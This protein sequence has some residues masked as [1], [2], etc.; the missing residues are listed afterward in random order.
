MMDIKIKQIENTDVSLYIENINEIAYTLISNC[1]NSNLIPVQISECH[2][3]NMKQVDIIDKLYI[4][5]KNYCNKYIEKFSIKIDRFINYIPHI[6]WLNI[7]SIIFKNCIYQH[8][9]ILSYNIDNFC[10]ILMKQIKNTNLTNLVIQL[11]ETITLYIDILFNGKYSEFIELFHS[12]IIKYIVDNQLELI[13]NS[14]E[15]VLS[16]IRLYLHKYNKKHNIFPLIN[17]D[18]NDMFHKL[19]ESDSI[20]NKDISLLYNIISNTL[21]ANDLLFDKRTDT[22]SLILLQ[23]YSID[24]KLL[25]IETRDIISNCFN[26]IYTRCRD[27]TV[28]ILETISNNKHMNCIDITNNITNLYCHCGYEIQHKLHDYHIILK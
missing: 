11:N 9:E 24:I 18:F 2:K 21:H 27:T 13:F 6:L 4:L 3:I 28:N 16:T 14:P 22:L 20:D 15:V 25:S 8:P 26:I 1:I 23:L 19:I 12:I 7:W 5:S 10:D 17:T